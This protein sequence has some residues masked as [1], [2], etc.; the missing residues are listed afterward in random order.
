MI[1]V[2]DLG[3]LAER[4]DKVTTITKNEIRKALESYLNA[5]KDQSDL[6]ITEIIPI[7]FS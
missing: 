6:V 4:C 5:P 1:D 7:P 2:F 3:I